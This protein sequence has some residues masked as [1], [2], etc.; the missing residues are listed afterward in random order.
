MSLGLSAKRFFSKTAVSKSKQEL[1]DLET[2]AKESIATSPEDDSL[3][4]ST[5][6]SEEDNTTTTFHFAFDGGCL[7]SK[8][9]TEECLELH[10]K[11]SPESEDEVWR[12]LRFEDDDSAKDYDEQVNEIAEPS[13]KFSDRNSP[14]SEI[15]SD[16][17]SS[18]ST[19]VESSDNTAPFATIL[20]SDFINFDDLASDVERQA[21]FAVEKIMSLADINVDAESQL[22]VITEKVKAIGSCE[23][24]D[25]SLQGGAKKRIEALSD[26]VINLTSD[27]TCL[28]TIPS[29]L[30]GEK[31][32]H[33]KV[34][35]D[36]IIDEC[37]AFDPFESNKHKESIVDTPTDKVERYSKHITVVSTTGNLEGFI[38]LYLSDEE[39]SILAASID[40]DDD[41]LFS[42]LDEIILRENP[43]Q[44]MD[45][46]DVNVLWEDMVM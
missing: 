31:C 38:N 25:G 23:G 33:L 35:G 13:I 3:W 32:D 26:Q 14:N 21:S 34:C 24:M 10:A 7:V 8:E 16:N 22:S 39:N 40:D 20:L 46:S 18:K 1:G 28:D 12:T 42:S 11:G 27:G 4:I 5:S 37:N 2:N 6:N 15:P 41:S 44:Y 45:P 19:P 43:K 9:E 30:C 17:I 29:N 36:I